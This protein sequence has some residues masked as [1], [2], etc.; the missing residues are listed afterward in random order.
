M[1]DTWS[2]GQYNRFATQRQQ[3]F[4]DLLALIEPHPGMR[5][6]DL[7]CGTGELTSMLHSHVHASETVGIDSSEQMLAKAPRNISGLRFEKQSIAD[8]AGAQEWDLIFSN[9]ALHWLPDHEA[10]FRRIAKGLRSGGQLAFQMPANFDHASHLSAAAVAQEEPFRSE[11]GGF[12]HAVNI[13]SP[14]SYSELLDE[15]GFEAQSVRLQVYGH[16]LASTRA[17]AEWTRGSLLTAYESRLSAES[18]ASFLRRYEEELIGRL[19]E[20]A[21]YFFSFKR[22]LIWGRLK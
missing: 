10:H 9:A 3:P 20:Q 2:P 15:I 19:G 1:T 13:L 18:F 8:F 7:G 16:R 5:I 6:V 21:P 11:L 22:L 14:A 17:V 12:V 4:H